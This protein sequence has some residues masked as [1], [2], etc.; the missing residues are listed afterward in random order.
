MMSFTGSRGS[1]LG[2]TNFYGKQV[3]SSE[4]QT[5]MGLIFGTLKIAFCHGIDLLVN[6]GPELLHPSQDCDLNVERRRRWRQIRTLHASAVIFLSCQKKNSKKLQWHNSSATWFQLYLLTFLYINHLYNHQHHSYKL[7]SRTVQQTSRAPSM[8]T[9]HKNQDFLN[10][11]FQPTHQGK[12]W[13]L[14]L[15]A[16]LHDSVANLSAWILLGPPW[17]AFCQQSGSKLPP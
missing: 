14:D 8:L 16:I 15:C 1:F 13:R 6:A 4:T 5:S 7:A 17:R 10:Q 12:R 9:T 3:T 11:L 2:D